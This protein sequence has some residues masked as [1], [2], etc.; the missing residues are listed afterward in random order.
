MLYAP[1]SD[2]AVSDIP[3]ESSFHRWRNRITDAE[4]TAITTAF[5]EILKNLKTDQQILTSSWIPGSDWTG[6][7]YEPIY[8]KCAQQNEAE[9]GKCFGLFL[10]VYLMEHPDRWIFLKCEKDGEPISGYTYFRPG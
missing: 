6:T 2:E 10:W 7:P 1:E 4:W 8:E 3:H 9:A 5:G